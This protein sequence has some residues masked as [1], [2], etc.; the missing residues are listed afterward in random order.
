MRIIDLPHRIIIGN[1]IID[2]LDEIIRNYG[3]EEP[4]YVVGRFTS[5]WSPSSNK[6]VVESASKHFLDSV[7]I[8]GDVVV[9]IGG[10]K[11]IDSA[12]YLSLRFGIPY[13][14]VP[15]L[16]STDGILSPTISLF[17]TYSKISIFHRPPILSIIDESV[18]LNSPKEYI[19]SGFGDVIAK[20][21]S[22]YDW[23]LGHTLKGEYFG[24]LTFTML[25]AA[26][27]HAVKVRKELSTPRGVHMLLESLILCGGGIGIQGSS[28][29]ASGSEHLISHAVDFLRYRE[30]KKLNPHGIQTGMFTIFTS[31]LQGRNWKWVKSMLSDAGFPKT[32][33]EIGIDYDTFLEAV[34]IAPKMRNRFTILSIK[35]L[36]RQDIINILQEVG[37]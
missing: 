19:L 20:Y 11:N 29:P 34:K 5:R 1:G 28:R 22:L 35:N 36:G 8:E 32:L 10:G 33:D 2:E 15:T 18:L 9:G 30:G 25:K 12:K 13:V 14:S 24:P 23:W 26:V 17:D 6:V 21:S 27:K 31:Y 37:L 7:E 3:F 4:V 16:P